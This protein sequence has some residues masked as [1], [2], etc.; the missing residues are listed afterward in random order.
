MYEEI[1]DD[2]KVSGL[3]HRPC[4][5]SAISESLSSEDIDFKFDDSP[6]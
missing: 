1:K 2:L 3:L 6:K 5:R 4:D